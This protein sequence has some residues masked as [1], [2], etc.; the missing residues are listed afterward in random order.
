MNSFKIKGPGIYTESG[1]VSDGVLTIE[2]GKI[3]AIEKN[4]VGS[5][6][7]QFPK[8]FHVVPGF[9]DLHIHGAHGVDV[10]DGTVTALKTLSRELPKE[11]TTSFLA[12]TMTAPVEKIEKVMQAVCDFQSEKIAGAN[13]L[14]IHLEGPFLAPQK[15]GAQN[16]EYLL[17]PNL[18][19]INAWQK[20]SN[21]AIKLVTLAPELPGALEF[22]RFLTSQQII[23]SM[24]HSDASYEQSLQAIK[25]GCT[26]VTH[27][28]NA[29]RGLHQREP[30]LVGAALLN[31]QVFGEMIADGLHLH[32]A[33]CE[34][35]LK[36]KT[37][38]KLV[39]VTDAMRAKC[40]CDG[41]YDL[42]GQS[43]S[44]KAGSAR[45]ANGTLAG[46]TLKMIDAFKNILR[47]TKC[48]MHD[49]IKM[50][51]ENP[52]KILNI[53]DLKGTIAVC[54]DADVVVLDERLDIVLTVCMGQVIY[55][56]SKSYEK[57]Y[58]N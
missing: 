55:E 3:V 9:I 53:F 48:Y 28:F 25:A 34:I 10:M 15:V 56:R 16:A 21:N 17:S 27:L 6:E 29:M 41:E 8:S 1:L 23:A 57:E 35:I 5:V 30:G 49:A 13:L 20:I 38:E 32:P 39:L 7:F 58:E 51:A 47:F 37:P 50:A 43:V 4:H 31:D 2:N 45:L 19:L 54:K 36:L 11:G 33:I 46:S 40:M 22:I 18:N 26:Q 14:G 42:G 12:T 24:G 52:A 44:V